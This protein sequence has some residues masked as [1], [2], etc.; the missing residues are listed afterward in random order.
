MKNLFFKSKFSFFYIS[1]AFQHPKAL[2]RVF[3]DIKI[4]NQK[5]QRIIIEVLQAFENFNEKI[6][7][8][9]YLKT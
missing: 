8:F 5:S 4:E 6:I 7:K 1:Q 3:F 2:P 9:S